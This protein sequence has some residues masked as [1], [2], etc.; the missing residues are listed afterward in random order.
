MNKKLIFAIAGTTVLLIGTVVV[1]VGLNRFRQPEAGASPELKPQQVRLTGVSAESV[2][3]NWVTE[4]A[5]YGFISYGETMSLGRTSQEA[6]KTTSHS[7]TLTALTPETTYYYKIGVGEDLFD[8]GGIPYSLTT[9]A[10]ETAT[11]KPTKEPAAQ[12]TGEL[13][14]KN[15]E[16]AL[17]SSNPTYDLNGDGT[18]NIVDLSLFMEQQGAP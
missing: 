9:P 6:E 2:T 11:D 7:V 16:L 8:D 14:L 13:T 10:Q 4:T 5:A 18:V 3:I 12:P 1:I 15:F 17:G